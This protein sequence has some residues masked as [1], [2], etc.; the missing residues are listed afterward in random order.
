MKIK[1]LA[2]IW[3]VLMFFC[4]PSRA[5]LLADDGYCPIPDIPDYTMWLRGITGDNSYEHALVDLLLGKTR[6]T[7]GPYHLTTF[8]RALNFERDRLESLN[9]KHYHI[10]VGAN[11]PEDH[12]QAHD[13]FRLPEPVAQ[14]LFGY[15]RLIIRREDQGKFA[16]IHDI[17]ALSALWVGQGLGWP[18]AEVWRHNGYKVV[19][20]VNL[21]S[22]FAMLSKKRFDFI[23]LAAHEAEATLKQLS[24]SYPELMIEPEIVIYYPLA[25]YVFV[26]NN[27]RLLV[28]RLQ[29]GL[30]QS[31]LDGSF[32]QLFNRRFGHII[33]SLQRPDIRVFTLENNT[34]STSG[35]QLSPVLINLPASA[36]AR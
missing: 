15:R 11:Y 10:H 2:F 27:N 16:R 20:S 22:L 8:K 28:E 7:Y 21:N 32:H 31:K 26:Q 24:R 14:G 3:L 34:I 13:F 9:A 30:K 19:E 17:Q 1:Q 29:K 35:V 36:K 6:F 33:G 5:Q 23:P 18:D 4:H 25:L 12:Y